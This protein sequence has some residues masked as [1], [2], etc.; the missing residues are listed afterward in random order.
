MVGSCHAAE[1]FKYGKAVLQCDHWYLY[2][3]VVPTCVVASWRVGGG[4]TPYILCMFNSLQFFLIT[5]DT[6]CCVC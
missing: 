2:G 1:L 3:G 4:L 6:F 5:G